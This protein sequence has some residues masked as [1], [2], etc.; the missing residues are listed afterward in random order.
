MIKEIT[1]QDLELAHEKMNEM[2]ARARGIDARKA[3]IREF[4]R[5]NKLDQFG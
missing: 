3:V 5:Q 2:R 4:E 1:P